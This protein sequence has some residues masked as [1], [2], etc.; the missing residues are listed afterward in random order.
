MKIEMDFNDYTWNGWG[1][2]NFNFIRN[3]TPKISNF[4]LETYTHCDYMEENEQNIVADKLKRI[5]EI[6]NE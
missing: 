1:F 5:V 2:N 3:I 6:I 4:L